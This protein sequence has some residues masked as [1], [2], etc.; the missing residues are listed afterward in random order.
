MKCPKCGNSGK[1]RWEPGPPM[2]YEHDHVHKVAYC[3][4]ADEQG[5]GC[6][7][8]NVKV[9]NEHLDVWCGRCGFPWMEPC[10][11]AKP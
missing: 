9:R 2:R 11:D 6:G 4:G 1:P 3:P 8:G 5:Y 7:M 10:M